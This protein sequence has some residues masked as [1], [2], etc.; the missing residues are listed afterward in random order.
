MKTFPCWWTENGACACPQGTECPSPGKHPLTK[1]GVKDATLD[2]EKLD[3]WRKRW[4]KANWAIAC[5]DG[6]FVVDLDVK[7]GK[8]GIQSLAALGK[9]PRTRTVRTGSGGLHLYF[10]GDASN[11]TSKLGAGIDTRGANGYVMAPGS[12]HISGRTYELSIDVDPVPAPVWLLEGLKTAAPA[13]VQ[14]KSIIE[15]ARDTLDAHGPAIEGQGGDLHTW[16]ACALLMHDF[17]LS[18]DEAWPLLQEWNDGCSPPWDEA[19]LRAKLQG[20]SKY[21][22]AEF[23][24]KLPPYE[25]TK[26]AIAR[27]DGG[28]ATELIAAVKKHAERVTE[29][30]TLA[31]ITRDLAQ[32]TGLKPKDFGFPKVRASGE[33]KKG[34]I[35]VTSRLNEVANEST[36]AIGQCETVF[37]R[38]GALCEVIPG[39]RIP[40]IHDLDSPRLQDLMSEFAT[41]VH[42]DGK[43]SMKHVSPP[44]P[45][46]AILQSR[47]QHRG[48]RVL[49]SV[50]TS[51]I[52][53]ADGSILA[54]K[55]YNETARVYLDPSVTVEV[56]DPTRADAKNAVAVF[57]DLLGDYK[58]AENA[59]ISSWL[60]ALLSPLVKA[61]TKNA[62]APLFII[63]ASSAGAGKSLLADILS[64]IVTGQPA[65]VRPYNVKDSN[66]WSKRLTAFVRAA[67]P[68]SVFDNV[69]G[70]IG[71]EALDRLI[72]SST[73]SDRVLGASDAPPMPN[74][75]T[76]VVT[77]NNVEPVNDTIRRS[78][79]IR[80]RVDTEKPQE[81]SGFKRPLLGEYVQ[82]RRAE[83]LEAALIILRG[84]HL[85]GR[86][87]M[88]LPA[89]G[90]FTE[91]SA[92]VRG[93]LVWAG[94]PDPFLTQ[95]RTAREA[96]ETENEV[97]D[98]WI[99]VIGATDG[100]AQSIA[101]LADQRGARD[102]LGS[103]EDMTPRRVR[104]FLNRFI[105]KPRGG[106]RI[107]RD[108]S[109]YWLES[110]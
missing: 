62:P 54:E 22:Q 65:E 64:R 13:R 100:L 63:S 59:D 89:W 17:A 106:R 71:D 10:L 43:G 47:R 61:A 6:L 49:E 105:D 86:P 7:P 37:Q 81:R 72:T 84:F 74:V 51:P 90:S 98:F 19:D 77:G 31:L 50:T 60:A 57:R 83:L 101:T 40:L 23:G 91:W 2:Q 82:E 58:F 36:A 28:D 108:G 56:G 97:H 52:F 38:A 85:A 104:V 66:E 109:R 35:L 110:V 88:D 9:V 107:M 42:D 94:C 44:G 96:T 45:V 76:W 12:S 30:S 4:P 32:T 26:R 103:R 48:I 27:F 25:A 67:A 41:Y 15:Q 1:N 11:T 87:D 21:G 53:L 5:G 20:G 73:W 102:I 78:L 69:A 24:C 3:A 8:N 46:A 39:D 34:E 55:G 16:R 33:L 92:L 80:V 29:P 70:P 14:T 99:E 93:A 95:Q 75:S 79:T 18:E 68:I